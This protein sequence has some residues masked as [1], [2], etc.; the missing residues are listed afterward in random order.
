MKT[1]MVGVLAA[2]VSALLIGG[3]GGMEA[4]GE[5][6]AAHQITKRS[7]AAFRTRT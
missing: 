2:A 3:R 6:I 5:P 4:S 1:L 7:S